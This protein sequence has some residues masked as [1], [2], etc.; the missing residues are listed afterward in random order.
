MAYT[1]HRDIGVKP[2]N[3]WYN[4]HRLYHPHTYLRK[5]FKNRFYPKIGIRDQEQKKISKY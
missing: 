5:I 2:K 4:Q 1:D 3:P